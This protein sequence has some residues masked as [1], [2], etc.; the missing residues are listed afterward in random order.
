MT[1]ARI[2]KRRSKSGDKQP[3]KAAP[4]RR[5]QKTPF[6][7]LAALATFLVAGAA[8][9]TSLGDMRVGAV[10]ATTPLRASF[11]LQSTQG[12]VV[13]SRSLLGRPYA[14]FLGFTHCPEL[15]ATT[16]LD[17]QTLVRDAG[18]GARD[19]TLYFITLDPERDTSDVLTEYV[20]AFGDNVVGLTGAERDIA[21]AAATLRVYYTKRALSDGDYVVDHTAL[22]YL[23]N[24]G[25]EVVDTL[26]VGEPRAKALQ[27][28]RA[29]AFGGRL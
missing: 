3:S 7:L 28:L 24:S 29:L 25:G 10:A 18:Y 14:I 13:D 17:V 12:G 1:R 27:K 19:M 5:A 21:A 9:M 15:C 4:E 23:V 11:K 26:V 6:A 22:V 20:K 8:G 16:L 2:S